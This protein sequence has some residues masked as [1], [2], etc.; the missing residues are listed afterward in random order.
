MNI[1]ALLN[2]L[3]DAD[4]KFEQAMLRGDSAAANRYSDIM[5]AIDAQIAEYKGELPALELQ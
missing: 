5:L 4:V 3:D 2:Q 1:Q